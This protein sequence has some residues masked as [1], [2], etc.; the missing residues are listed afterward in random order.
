MGKKLLITIIILA[1]ISLT[2]VFA[3]QNNSQD[4]DGNFSMN[5]PIGKCD[6]LF[7]DL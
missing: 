4:F 3:V 1:L 2:V 7:H 6:H 5:V